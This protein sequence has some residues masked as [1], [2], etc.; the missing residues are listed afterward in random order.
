MTKEVSLK[1]QGY[2]VI[3]HLCQKIQILS[4]PF[5][6]KYMTMH[7]IVRK[8]THRN[9]IVITLYSLFASVVHISKIERELF[10]VIFKM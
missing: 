10:F 9:K 6:S 4:F 5:Y 2:L 7:W 1:I 3:S 8:D